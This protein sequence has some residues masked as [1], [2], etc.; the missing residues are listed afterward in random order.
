MSFNRLEAD[1][2]VV[3]AQSQTQTCWTNN[4]PTLTTF[5]TSSTQVS[6]DSGNYYITVYDGNPTGSATSAQFEIAYGNESGGGALAFNNTAN[7]GVSPASTIFGQYRTLVLEDENA[8]FVFG[9]Y[10]GS[11]IYVISVERAAYK[12]SLFPGS[13][14]LIISGSTSA[15]N[16][17]LRLTD[18]SGMV[19]V[20]Q[21]YGTQRAYQ[22]ISGSEGLAYNSGSGGTGYTTDKGSYGLFL[23]DIGTLIL[24]GD[25][26]DLDSLEGVNLGTVTGS[27]TAGNNP[28]RLLGPIQSGSSFALN[29]EETITSDFV[30]IRAR[31]S[32][33]NYSENPSYISGST[34]EVIY[35]Y[36]INNPQTY[37]TTVGMYND[38]NELL[39]TAKLSKPLNKDF[40]KEAL[41]RVKLDF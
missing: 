30:F 15:G 41:I 27:N 33:F 3:S 5:F 17:T 25:A 21:Y 32:E 2:F 7:P 1:D 6:S 26:L 28:L 18:D 8:G 14:D 29:S 9:N 16:S 13:L 24:N 12:E 19:S 40:T 10:S 31:N 23:P 20:P 22:I 34:G 35:N 37:I 36:F 11:S 38:S 39:A 4:L